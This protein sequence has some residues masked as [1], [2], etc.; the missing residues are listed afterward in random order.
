MPLRDEELPLLTLEGAMGLQ[1]G[2]HQRVCEGL[3]QGTR[4]ELRRSELLAT[5]SLFRCRER[6]LSPEISLNRRY[7]PCAGTMEISFVE[8]VVLK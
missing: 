6:L 2:C 3:F 4:S 7:R 5:N 1:P 8:V